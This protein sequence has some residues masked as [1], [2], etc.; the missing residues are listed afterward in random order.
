[1]RVL[2]YVTSRSFQGLTIPVP[3]QNSCL[4]EFAKAQKLVYVL[5]P[6]E[7]YFQN[8]YMQLFTLVKSL[9]E[10]DIILDGDNNEQVIAVTGVSS[11]IAAQTVATSG[12]GVLSNANCTRR[13]VKIYDQDQSAAI[14][15]W[16][17]D[18]VKTHTPDDISVKKQK[19]ISAS[20]GKV[21]VTTDNNESFLQMSRDNFQLS[22][23]DLNG[24]SAGGDVLGKEFD[25]VTTAGTLSL[26]HISEAHET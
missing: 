7:H 6:L 15:A 14:F 1:M 13:R 21:T 18:Y 3:A 2:G 24:N 9:K 4:R 19:I 10:G 20:G 26:I 8:C 11:N 25:P 16:P 12:V 23:Y 17:R 22:I 5:P